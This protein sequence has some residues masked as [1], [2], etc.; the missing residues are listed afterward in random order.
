[1]EEEGSLVLETITGCVAGDEA[2]DGLTG[3]SAE[4]LLLQPSSGGQ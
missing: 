1:M 2:V 3:V 4:C